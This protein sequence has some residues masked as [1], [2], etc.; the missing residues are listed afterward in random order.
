MPSSRAAALT[1]PSWPRPPIRGT[2]AQLAHGSLP[3]PPSV[4]STQRSVR[5]AASPSAR[6]DEGSPRSSKDA[7]RR[8]RRRRCAQARAR[9]EKAQRL[10]PMASG[11]EHISAVTLDNRERRLKPDRLDRSF[12]R[13][14]FGRVV[15]SCALLDLNLVERRPRVLRRTDDI[16]HFHSSWLTDSRNAARRRSLAD[17]RQPRELLFAEQLADDGLR[18]DELWQCIRNGCYEAV[19]CMPVRP[20]P[21][22]ARTKTRIGASRLDFGAA[23]LA[24]PPD[25]LDWPVGRCQPGRRRA[26]R[27]GGVCD[28]SVGGVLREPYRPRY[29]DTG[30]FSPWDIRYASV[31]VTPFEG[32][33]FTA[34]SRHNHPL[35][36]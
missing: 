23:A 31:T 27:F 11:N 9:L 22:P 18:P 5:H 3:S 14:D 21:A 17:L 30:D 2:V 19:R 6:C 24:K 33:F 35:G 10:K 8:R 36:F 32:G 7:P 16:S 25:V 26:C 28:A 1:P 13:N 29:I 20:L 4:G 12:E 34:E 15:W